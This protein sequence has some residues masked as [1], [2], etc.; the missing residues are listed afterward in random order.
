MSHG[1]TQSSLTY[2]VKAFYSLSVLKAE[3][4]LWHI[5]PRANE[6]AHTAVDTLSRKHACVLSGDLPTAHVFSRVL[7]TA[8]LQL[9]TDTIASVVVKDAIVS[10]IYHY[11]HYN[12]FI[13]IAI[14]AIAAAAT[15][16]ATTTTNAG[17]GNTA[18]VNADAQRRHQH[19]QATRHLEFLPSSN[20]GLYTSEMYEPRP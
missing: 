12:Y 15:T 2:P 20:Q 4:N 9:C 16:I 14:A 6:Y 17:A 5:N 11:Y 7:S 19:V 8:Y 3:C 13:I 10:V 1:P 18:R